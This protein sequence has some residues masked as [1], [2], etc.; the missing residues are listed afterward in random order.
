MMEHDEL[1][2]GY[3]PY[4]E[5]RKTVV[6]SLNGFATSITPYLDELGWADLK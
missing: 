3:W 5:S 6:Y 1:I 2:F 4:E